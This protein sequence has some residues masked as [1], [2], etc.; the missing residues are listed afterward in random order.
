[1]LGRRLLLGSEGGEGS[2][3]HQP[4]A[5]PGAGRRQAP[6]VGPA[7]HRVGAHPEQVRR[8]SD[9]KLAHAGDPRREP[10]ISELPE[11][12]GLV[13]PPEAL[14][15]GPTGHYG[16]YQQVTSDPAPV[17]AQE[18]RWPSS[19]S[20]STRTSSRSRSG[21]TTSPSRSCGPPV[22]SGT[23]ARRRRG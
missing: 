7:P 3:V 17:A 18:D 11:P 2:A 1:G 5:A 21:C 20:T 14:G 19:R 10:R 4:L 23:S 9:A 12:A 6:F 15:P 22:T 13:V 8:L 16:G